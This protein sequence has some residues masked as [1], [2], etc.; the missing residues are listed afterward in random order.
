LEEAFAKNQRSMIW[1]VNMDSLLKMKETTLLK[2]RFL[3][4]EYSSR[5]AATEL[6]LKPC[7]LGNIYCI[8]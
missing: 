2:E 6:F 7:V 3:V 5:E 1:L 8:L 4:V